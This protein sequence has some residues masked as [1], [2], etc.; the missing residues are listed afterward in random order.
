MSLPVKSLC[1]DTSFLIMKKPSKYPQNTG[2]KSQKDFSLLRFSFYYLEIVSC[3]WA[4]SCIQTPPDLL[5]HWLQ[6]PISEIL[7]SQALH[8]TFSVSNPQVI[9][10]LILLDPLIHSFSHSL[11]PSS[12][13]HSAMPHGKAQ[14]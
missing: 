6:S 10:I 8:F 2:I 11:N 5:T 1:N 9:N 4:Y 7:P 14:Q 13:S 3:L 12:S